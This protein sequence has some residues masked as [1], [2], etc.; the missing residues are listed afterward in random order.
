LTPLA[1]S[2]VFLRDA[3]GLLRVLGPG[4]A[5]RWCWLAARS[6]RQVLA[7]GRL[8]SADAAMGCGPFR[9]WHSGR[10]AWIGGVAVIG[11]IREI[12]AREVYL[13]PGYLRLPAEGLVVDLGANMGVFTALALS[14]GPSVRVLAV[15]PTEAACAEWWRQLARN[16]WTGRGE[17]LTA[18]VGEATAKQADMLRRLPECR[19]SPFLTQEDVAERLGTAPI[20]FLKCDVEGSEFSLLRRGSPLLERA[21]QVAVEI[22]DFAGDRRQ[23][24]DALAAQGF[25]VRLSHDTPTD[26]VAL[27]R[28]AGGE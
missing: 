21:R 10:S 25:A 18:F 3:L 26:C 2:R 6:H 5:A 8:G 19:P 22:H 20:A 16:G 17:V 7:S 13:G 14:R 24:L 23:V 27:G 9:A 28:R 4:P 1:A 12:W 11:G 15:E